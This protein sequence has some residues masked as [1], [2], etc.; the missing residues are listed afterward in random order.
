MG[1]EVDQAY[2]TKL[3]N[4]Y[5]KNNNGFIGVTEFGR[6]DEIFDAGTEYLKRLQVS[7]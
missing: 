1:F 3:I 7:L 5:D 2:I 4:K 6:Y